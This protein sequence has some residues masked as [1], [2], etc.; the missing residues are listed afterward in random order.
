MMNNQHGLTGVMET[1]DGINTL[2]LS[3][4]CDSIRMRTLVLEMLA[5]ICFVPPNGEC[6]Q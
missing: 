5:A 3:L 6:D 4:D 1:P 2:A